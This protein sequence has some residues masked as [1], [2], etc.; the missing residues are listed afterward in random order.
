MSISSRE[1]LASLNILACVAMADGKIHAN[2]RTA[3]TVALES[4]VHLEDASQIDIQSVDD[5]L[6]NAQGERLLEY[7]SL[8]SSPA[9]RELAYNTAFAMANV[10][11]DC[12]PSEQEILEILQKTFGIPERKTK[13]LLSIL[14][15]MRQAFHR[16]TPVVPIA[17]A[18]ERQTAVS[19]LCLHYATLCAMFWVFPTLNVAI[20][21]DILVCT[22][23]CQM[24]QEIGI[25]WQMP[26]E[27]IDAYAIFKGIISGMNIAGF[28]DPAS[29]LTK[30]VPT[31]ATIGGVA[32]TY[33]NTWAL[34][35]SVNLYFSQGSQGQPV[36]MEMLNQH[37]RH[38]CERG[39]Q[40]YKE[41]ANE[42]R[43]KMASLK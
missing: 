20:A 41:N 32:N 1:A 3:L 43:Q 26:P 33:A 22:Y 35:D 7:A 11:G 37:F 42:V 31:G 18:A 30:M 28:R 38:A 39:M 8:V 17:D 21:P 27:Q 12:A 6:R 14:H 36:D 9:A 2:E 19:Q 5:L 13:T 25:C 16:Q 24:I 29:N 34:G 23:Q 4:V 40:L 15:N 10:D